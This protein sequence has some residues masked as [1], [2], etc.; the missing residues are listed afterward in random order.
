[1]LS[2]LFFQTGCSLAH[3]QK[4][5]I[6]VIAVE[7]LGINDIN[8]AKESKPTGKS[9][10]DLMCKNSVRFTHAYTPSLLSQSALSSIMTGLY[11][12]EHNVHNNGPDFL[13]ASL[14]NVAKVAVQKGFHTAFFSGGPPALRSSGLQ[15]GFEHFEDNLTL[16]LKKIFRSADMTFSLFSNWT[17]EVDAPFFS[18][19]FV[20]DLLFTSYET[21]DEF[22]EKRNLTRESQIENLDSNLGLLFSQMKKEKTW[23]Q[24]NIFLVGLNGHGGETSSNRNPMLNLHS[25]NTQ[26]SLLIKPAGK[27][28]DEGL[29]WSYDEPVT[30]PDIGRTLFDM[31]EAPP[32]VTSKLVVNSL[33]DAIKK[34]VTNKPSERWIYSESYWGSWRKNIGILYSLRKNNTLYI[35]DTHRHFFNT[36]TDRQETSDIS[37][38]DP[39][40]TAITSEIEM[41]K[42]LINLPIQ[43]TTP[44][45][46]RQENVLPPNKLA[47]QFLQQSKWKELQ[48]LGL[49]NKKTDWIALSERNLGLNRTPF[50]NPCLKLLDVKIPSQEERRL[51]PNRNTLILSDFASTFVDNQTESSEA[52][53]QHNKDYFRKKITQILRDETLFS[54]LSITNSHLNEIWNIS[55]RKT[56]EHLTF[57]LALHHPRVARLHLAQ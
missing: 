7:N 16:N 13:K 52:A 18:V 32:S 42:K 31:L 39:S 27:P 35:Q 33:F 37:I 50:S 24:T 19:I 56:A 17:K 51:C 5:N 40:I 3:Q 25:E 53:D 47:L 43:L 55:E 34:P 29:S 4:S 1:M 11:P 28:R 10:M 44:T 12:F 41:I 45:D 21:V 46:D 20:P 48:L 22:G 30:L 6:L 57:E 54:L 26:I 49:K 8:C 2:F 36:L 14:P 38:S 9:G 15:Q 23:D